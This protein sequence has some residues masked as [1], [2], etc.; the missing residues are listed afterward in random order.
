MVLVL[1]LVVGGMGFITT[2]VTV[3]RYLK[4]FL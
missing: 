3:S 1:P 2:G 4:R